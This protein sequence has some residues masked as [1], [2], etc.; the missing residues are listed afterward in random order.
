[1][2]APITSKGLGVRMGSEQLW[3]RPNAVLLIYRH[4]AAVRF[5]KESKSGTE[6][7]KGRLGEHGRS[8]GTFGQG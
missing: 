2:H 5:S 7:M 8:Q 4:Y 6:N 3:L 1:M